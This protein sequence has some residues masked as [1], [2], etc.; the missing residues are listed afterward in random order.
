MRLLSLIF[1]SCLIFT[2]YLVK[3]PCCIY[4]WECAHCYSYSACYQCTY[5][6]KYFSHFISLIVYIRSSLIRWLE[7]NIRS[8]DSKYYQFHT[9]LV[10]MIL[11]M[12][13]SST[14][15]RYRNAYPALHHKWVC[16]QKK[17]RYKLI[18]AIY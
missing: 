14:K 9:L 11:I 17:R 5:Y 6:C 16:W 3:S 15:I 10:L 4:L 1:F 12:L 13:F 2:P 8:N 18:T 7:A